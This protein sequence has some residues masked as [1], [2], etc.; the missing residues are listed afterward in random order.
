M[1]FLN[2]INLAETELFRFY[3]NPIFNFDD[4]LFDEFT[5]LL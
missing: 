2:G 4:P 5:K 3:I 1:D